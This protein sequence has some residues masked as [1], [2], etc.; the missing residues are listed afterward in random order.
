MGVDDSQNTVVTVVKGP[1]RIADAEVIPSCNEGRENKHKD[2]KSHDSLDTITTRGVW[3]I[4]MRCDAMRCER[5][6]VVVVVDLHRTASV[7]GSLDVAGTVGA[8]GCERT[9]AGWF[10]AWG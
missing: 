4:T 3:G 7:A 9:R 10:A 8:A 1:Q 6:S 5:I 2:K